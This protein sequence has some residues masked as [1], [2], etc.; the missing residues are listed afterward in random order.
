MREE[1]AEP[2]EADALLAA[3]RWL[4]E[5]GPSASAPQRS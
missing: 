3:M 1:A 5:R 2:H 4:A